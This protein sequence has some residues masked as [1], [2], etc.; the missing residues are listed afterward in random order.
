MQNI[1]K[2]NEQ[3]QESNNKNTDTK[4]RV[5]VNRMEMGVGRGQNG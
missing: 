3:T 4:N 1:K 2:L 5:G